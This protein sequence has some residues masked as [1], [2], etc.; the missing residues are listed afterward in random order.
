MKVLG[1]LWYA[2]HCLGEFVREEERKLP[3]ALF[4]VT[5]DH[6]SRR[7]PNAQPT[8]FERSA[9][10]LVLYGKD[11]LQGLSIPLRTVGSHIDIAPTLINLAAPKGFVYYSVGRNLLSAN[12]QTL[13]IGY[14]KV[15]GPDFIADLETETIHPLPGRPLPA[16]LPDVAKLKTT[17]NEYYGIAWWRVKR[18]PQL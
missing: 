6:W 3:H 13:A 11:V 2:D 8:F 12:S 16:S 1:H 4:A 7:F 18:G 17:L 14:H 5:G 10:P 9:V 15:V